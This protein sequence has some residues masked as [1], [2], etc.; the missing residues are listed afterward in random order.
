MGKNEK[1][2]TICMERYEAEKGDLPQICMCCGAPATVR[3][4]QIFCSGADWVMT[5]LGAVVI[6]HDISDMTN[7]TAVWTCFCERHGS[8]WAKRRLL[9]VC[10]LAGMVFLPFGGLTFLSTIELGGA[11]LLMQ[12]W[13]ASVGLL[14]GWIILTVSV[15]RH[16]IRATEVTVSSITLTGVCEEYFQAVED[17]RSTKMKRS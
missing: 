11:D 12:L 15:Y 5:I 13:I 3:T 4:K 16:T 17:Y 14:I 7:R 6:R 1:I 10:S 2:T 8:Y 9:V